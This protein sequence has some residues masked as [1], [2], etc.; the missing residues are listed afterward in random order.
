MDLTW[1]RLIRTHL[2]RAD[3]SGVT[4]E[5]AMLHGTWLREATLADCYVHGAVVRRVRVEGATI[6][7]L[8]TSPSGASP[9]TTDALLIG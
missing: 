2:R 4:L 8:V 3:L 5:Y 6:H 7:H 1:A 9:L